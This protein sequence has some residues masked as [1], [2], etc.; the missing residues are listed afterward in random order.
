MRAPTVTSPVSVVLDAVADGLRPETSPTASPVA[1]AV[2][3]SGGEWEPAAHLALISSRLV[4][5]ETQP[6]RLVVL[7]PPRHGKSRLISC[8]TPAWF[9]GCY[10]DRH[11]LLASYEAE[12]AATWGRKARDVLDVNGERFFGVRIRAARRRPAT[13]RSTAPG[14]AWPPQV[15]AGP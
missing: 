7:T 15:W 10:P 11:V 14:A 2:A 3:A 6:L 9:L 8:Y 5:M 4:E 1:L 12:F 13:G